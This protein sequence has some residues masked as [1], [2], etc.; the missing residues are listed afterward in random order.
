VEDGG[1]ERNLDVANFQRFERG[2]LQ[3]LRKNGRDF[4]P[5]SR[6]KV[7]LFVEFPTKC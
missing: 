5:K 3:N 6:T 2:F 4:V 7:M 1:G